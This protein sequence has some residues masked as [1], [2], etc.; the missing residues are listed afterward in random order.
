M[1]EL[2]FGATALFGSSL[3]WPYSRELTP[4]NPRRNGRAPPLAC[5]RFSPRPLRDRSRRSPAQ[6]VSRRRVNGVAVTPWTTIE[7]TTQAIVV[8]T[9]T[10]SSVRASAPDWTATAA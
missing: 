5:D 9:T 8:H 10:D 6:C 3:M 2:L 1:R 4:R 7:R